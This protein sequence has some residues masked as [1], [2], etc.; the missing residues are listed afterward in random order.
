MPHEVRRVAAFFWQVVSPLIACAVF[1]LF[2]LAAAR[3]AVDGRFIS[4]AVEKTIGSLSIILNAHK[5][6]LGDAALAFDPVRRLGGGHTSVMTGLLLQGSGAALGAAVRN[7]I[8]LFMVG[9]L[10]LQLPARRR[11]E[12]ASL[13]LFGHW[14]T[15]R[16]SDATA[17]LTPNNWRVPARLV[18]PYL[19]D[20]ASFVLTASAVLFATALS[21][22]MARARVE[23]GLPLRPLPE[24][25]TRVFGSAMAVLAIMSLRPL[26]LRLGAANDAYA[27]LSALP[28]SF[29]SLLRRMLLLGMLV[30]AIP[31]AVVAGLWARLLG[32]SWAT[33]IAFSLG[34]ALIC[35]GVLFSGSA[36]QTVMWRHSRSSR[37]LAGSL[38]LLGSAGLMVLNFLALKSHPGWSGSIVAIA[39]IA[40]TAGA[41]LAS[42]GLARMVATREP[43]TND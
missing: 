15:A 27:R 23:L 12:P 35:A 9:V 1:L 34:T 33:A 21:L 36:L 2:F 22:T 38:W 3:F 17:A 11:E 16:F 40:A 41:L 4:T 10:L 18:L 6:R 28:V 20:G 25:V 19:K 43:W 39:F 30:A 31:Q 24:L 32:G 13:R 29:E 37:D 7:R 42:G 26:L 8:I 14:I 5:E